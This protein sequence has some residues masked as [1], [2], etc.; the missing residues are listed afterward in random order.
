MKKSEIVAL[1][2]EK[3]VTELLW[4]TI[5]GTKE[6]NSMRGLTKQTYKESQWL[7]EETS[8]RFDLNLEEIQEEMSK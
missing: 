6:V 8:K 2:N 3:L 1:S 4:N 5:R 7:L